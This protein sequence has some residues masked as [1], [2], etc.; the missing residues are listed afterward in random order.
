MAEELRTDTCQP[1]TA[2]HPGNQV[3]R[4]NPAVLCPGALSEPNPSAGAPSEAQ[5][6]VYVSVAA[7]QRPRTAVL[8]F[9]GRLRLPVASF[10]CLKIMAAASFGEVGP[11][12][13]AGM[14]AYECFA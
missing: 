14:G 7:R 6:Q 3:C 5:S 8:P 10:C 2:P 9:P 12:C 13:P 1:R 11:I 4:A